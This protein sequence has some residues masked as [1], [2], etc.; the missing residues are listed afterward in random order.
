MNQQPEMTAAEK[1]LSDAL[2]LAPEI[3][4]RAAETEA[5][6][7]A[8]PDLVEKLRKIGVFRMFVPKRFGGLDL[9]LPESIDILTTLSAADASIGWISFIGCHAP[10]FFSMLPEKSFERIYA[11]GPDVIDA[12]SVGIGSGAFAETTDGGYR[13]TGRFAFASGCQHADWIL[14]FCL[15]T[16]DGAPAAS[17]VPGAPAIRVVFSPASEWQIEDTWYSGGLRG[18]G[19]HHVALKDHFIAEEMTAD[20]YAPKPEY[21][22]TLLGGK[23]LFALPLHTAAV[24]VGI[25]EGALA[26][27]M[28]IANSGK[29][30][31]RGQQSLKESPHFHFE[32]GRAEAELRAARA[33]L[34]RQVTDDWTNV[35]T[36]RSDV[37]IKA[38]R[39]QM[40]AWVTAACVRVV[41]ACYTL[42]G[43]AVIY[44][45]SPL[46]RRMQDIHTLTQHADVRQTNFANVGAVLMSLPPWDVRLRM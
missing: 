41:D 23:G 19:S 21:R 14:G 30:P 8:P 42:G 32:L 37:M 31:A 13:V 2:A 33:V 17:A 44:D 25:A 36:A 6:R 29:R 45:S 22:G 43:S 34:E 10:F 12:G 40:A 16:K 38:R 20:I 4:E 24:A 1:L 18:T 46:R 26:D 39:G 9:T 11:D 28:A 7:R 35:Q 5:G 15:V 3:A 27:V